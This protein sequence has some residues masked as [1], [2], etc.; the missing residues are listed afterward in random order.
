MRDMIA[1]VVETIAGAVSDIFGN[2]MPTYCDIETADDTHTLVTSDG[3]LLSGLRIDGIRDAVG[4]DE[5]E[6]LMTAVSRALQSFLS[7]DGFTVD[8]FASRDQES[9]TRTLEGLSNKVSATCKSIGLELDDVID[10]NKRTMAKYTADEAIYLALWSRESLLTAHESKA[11]RQALAEVAKKMPPTSPG[12]QS[13][14][15]TLPALRE[16]HESTIQSIME[17]LRRAGVLCE[18]LGAHEMLARARNAIDP[19]FTPSNWRPHLI[20]DTVPLLGS[21]AAMLR[22]HDKRELDFSD[23]QYPPVAWQM[24][25]R[26]AYRVNAKHVV[27]GDTAY[28][29]LFVE[30]PP[31]EVMPFSVLF[32][33]LASAGVPWRVMIRLDGGGMKYSGARAMLSDIMSFAGNHNKM[34][35]DTFKSLKE[36]ERVHGE[37]L[38]RFRMSFCTWAPAKDIEELS[39]RAS[40]LVQNISSWGQCEVREVSGDPMAGLVSTVPF[41]TMQC[42]ATPSVA[43]LS[44]AVRML[45]IVRPAS[46][47]QSGS[48]ILRTIDGRLMPFQPGSSMQSTWNYLLTGRPGSGKSVQMLNLILSGVLQPG[49]SRLPKVGIV[50]IGPSASYFARMLR[51]SLP[52]GRQHEVATFR[53]SMRTEDAINPFDTPLGCRY[54]TDLH[55]AFLANIVTQ[56]ATP[57]EMHAPFPRMSEMVNKVV[58]ATYE[59][60]SGELSSSVPKKFAFGLEEKVDAVVRNLGYRVTNDTAWWN[61]VDFLFSK[62]YTHEATL[63]QRHAVPTLADIVQLPQQV[64]DLYD[65]AKVD[66]GET[67]SDAFSSLVS[68]AT[69]DFPNLASQTKF[70]IGEA[71]V[72]TINLEDVAKTGSPAA[73]RQTSVMYMLASYALTKDYRINEELVQQMRMPKMYTDYHTKKVR[74]NKEDLKWIAYDE[75]HRTSK[76]PQVRDSIFIDM[77]EGRKYNTGVILASQGAEDFPP[78]MR[79]FATATFVADAGTENN[80]KALRDFFDLSESSQ[81]IMRRHVTGAGASGAPMFVIMSTKKGNFQQLMVSTLGTETLWAL[82]TTTEDVMVREAVCRKLGAQNGRRAL[83]KTFP[84]GGCKSEIERLRN[85][86]HADAIERVVSDVLRRA[87]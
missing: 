20:G 67:M 62:G 60:L 10:A 40:R 49:M 18:Q 25:P 48:M 73:E 72:V 64:R 59:R 82:S 52:K 17:S 39:R 65:K 2:S 38:V 16:I 66:T 47:W 56:I 31:R 81:D 21:G 23:I 70:D 34:I 61:I 41:L 50:D 69:R 6:R 85:E 9:V 5:F 79:E 15:S 12:S 29:P 74:E 13:L 3:T 80:I 27:V 58:D 32:D 43:P 87:A 45:P 46:L 30:I 63:A 76:S 35:A 24:F 71:R 84:G 42:A 26:D 83:A 19:G 51:D 28:A 86:G 36:E 33:K 68:S 22:E 14:V 1:G 55:R 11:A 37:T 57:A 75:F 44:H 4:P 53:I 54:P 77:R 7:R 78:E 8:V